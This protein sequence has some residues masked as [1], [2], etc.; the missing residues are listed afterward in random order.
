MKHISK[1]K[2]KKKNLQKVILGWCYCH[3]TN[4]FLPLPLKKK[5]KLLFPPHSI[6]HFQP[7]NHSLTLITIH[8]LLLPI[9]PPPPPPPLHLLLLLLL[10]LIL[11]LLYGFYSMVNN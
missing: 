11:L 7:T 8:H 10:L 6:N 5:F 1:Y 9:P 2:K 3:P 4:Y